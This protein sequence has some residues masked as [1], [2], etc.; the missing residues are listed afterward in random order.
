MSL[1]NKLKSTVPEKFSEV[2][3]RNARVIIKLKLDQVLEQIVTER[4]S[5]AN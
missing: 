2:V 4:I 1:L 3:I 5:D